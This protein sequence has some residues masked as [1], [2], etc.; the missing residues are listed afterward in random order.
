MH[1]QD[2]S[3][4]LTHTVFFRQ[5]SVLIF[6]SKKIQSADFY[7]WYYNIAETNANAN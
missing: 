1:I 4:K 3:L 6:E 5:I 2:G 7:L